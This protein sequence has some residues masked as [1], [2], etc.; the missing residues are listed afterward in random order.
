M[1]SD[2]NPCPLCQSSQTQ[3]Y[4]QD[5]RRDYRQCQQCQLVY[6]PEAFHLSASDEKAEYDKHENSLDD[7][8]YLTFLSRVT[9]PLIKLYAERGQQAKG[10]DFGCGPA[11]ALAQHMSQA[12]HNMAIYDLY[13]F[14]DQIVLN[15]T[16]DFITCTEV[17]EHLAAPM[18][19]LTWATGH[20]AEDGIIAIMTKRVRDLDS[21]KHWHYKN[22]PTHICFYSEATFEWIAENFRLTLSIINK[23]VVFLTRT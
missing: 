13:Y 16:Y 15:E 10:L 11:P 22:D 9:D 19:F 1:V 20:L 5:K 7:D 12:G 6:V 3:H 23:D 14:P 21:F 4:W 8:G 18:E 17:I 2:D